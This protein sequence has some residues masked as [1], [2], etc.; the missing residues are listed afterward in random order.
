MSHS[1]INMPWWCNDPIITDGE[2]AEIEYAPF[3]NIE[4]EC[5]CHLF[6]TELGLSPH[7]AYDAKFV[8]RT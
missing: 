8:S 5:V 1:E 2:A 3:T 7:P 6:D 4:C